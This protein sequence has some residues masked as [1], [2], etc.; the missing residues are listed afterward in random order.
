MLTGKRLSVLGDSISTYKDF[1]CDAA[2]NAT[3]EYNPYFY[4]E[5]FPLNKTYWKLVMDRL[6]MSLCVNNSWS[7]G[8]LSG[9]DSTAGVSRAANLCRDDGTS[10]D[11]IIVFMGIND[12]GRGVDV[13]VFREDYE[14]TL[15]TIKKKHPD[16]LV[17][18]VNL[19][20]RDIM[21]RR[22]A[23]EFNSAIE[24]AVALCGDNFFIAD[25]FSSRLKDDFYYMNTLDGL[26][27]DEDGMRIIAEIVEN[28]ITNKLKNAS[29]T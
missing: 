20:D 14:R 22:R 17:C 18:C 8:N 25:L 27:P 24:G 4:R 16:A 21:L 11:V 29:N 10:P 28:A 2:A 1:S 3:T 19:P 26:H 12:L 13:S 5:P 7:G 15:L 23:A 9:T 6:G